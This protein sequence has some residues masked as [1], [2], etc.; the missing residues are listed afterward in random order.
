MHDLSAQQ[1][2][3]CTAARLQAAMWDQCGGTQSSYRRNGPDPATCCP[4]SA[5]CSQVTPAYYQCQPKG[6]KPSPP[7]EPRYPATCAETNRVSAGL[8][9]LSSKVSSGLRHIVA[10]ISV[11]WRLGASCAGL[12]PVA[13]AA[14]P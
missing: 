14:V 10:L 13:A 5:A 3:P 12:A 6:W 11:Y 2:T 4:L 7:A 1:P 9:C 8:C